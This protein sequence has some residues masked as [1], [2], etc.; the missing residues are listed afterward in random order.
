MHISTISSYRIKNVKHRVLTSTIFSQ[1]VVVYYHDDMIPP[2]PSP[3]H[4]YSFIMCII[5][6]FLCFIRK[7]RT[8][9]FFFLNYF[10]YNDKFGV[11]FK[12]DWQHCLSCA[13]YMQ[14]PFIKALKLNDIKFKFCILKPQL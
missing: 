11:F 1:I 4:Q 12:N 5:I 7:T 13:D 2:S 3:P 8:F 10:A 9:L 6:V 14:L